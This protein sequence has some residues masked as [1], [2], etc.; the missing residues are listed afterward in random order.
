MC[1]DTLGQSILVTIP[2]W[3][4]LPT[5]SKEQEEYDE[6]EQ[7]SYCMSQDKIAGR[8]VTW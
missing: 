8:S 4:S 3:P 7:E 2:S 1:I 6:E 5:C